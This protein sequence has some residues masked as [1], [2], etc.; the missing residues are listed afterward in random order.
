MQDK[1]A[2]LRLRKGKQ[3]MAF[4]GPGGYKIEW[5]PGTKLLPLVPAP[6]GHLVIPC[7]NFEE[8]GKNSKEDAVTFMTD[9]SVGDTTWQ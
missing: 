5:S 1:D 7:D 2:V 3:M 8:V 9:H 6:S 4:P